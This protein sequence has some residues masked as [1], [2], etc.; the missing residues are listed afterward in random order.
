MTATMTDDMVTCD[1]C[2]AP[3]TESLYD[4]SHGMCDRCH[5]KRFECRECREVT[6]KSDAHPTNRTLCQDCGDD[7]AE[8]D[9]LEALDKGADTLREL[10]EAIIDS[11]DLA[12]VRK[13]LAALKKLAPK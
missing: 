7:R 5:S 11:G 8:A 9:R 2:E 12:A 13:A 10:A 1:G 6:L 4:A 3:M